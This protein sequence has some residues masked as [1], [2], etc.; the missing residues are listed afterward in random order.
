MHAS[1]A[2]AI[3]ETGHW[4]LSSQAQRLANTKAVNVLQQFL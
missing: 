2:Q 4:L 1:Y 3:K